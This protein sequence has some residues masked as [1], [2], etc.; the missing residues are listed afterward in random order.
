MLLALINGLVFGLLVALIASGLSLVFGVTRIINLAHGEFYMV[1][2][3]IT[4]YI[5]SITGSFLLSLIISPL[6]IAGLALIANYVLLKPLNYR[7]EPTIIATIGMLYVIQQ[8]ILF[9]F[10]PTSKAVSPPFNYSIELGL[11]SYPAYQVVV[12]I[13]ALLV[14]VM[15]WFIVYRT[16]V[17]YFMRASQQNQ[18]M[19]LVLGID[20]QRI[21]LYVLC[22]SGGLA[23]LAGSLVS[24]ITS[25]YYLM[26]LDILML[27]LIVT[28][29]GGLGSLE[30]T[31]IASIFITTLENIISN[32]YSPTEARIL[33][34]IIL[35]LVLIVRPL[36]LFRRG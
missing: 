13:I 21:Y 9:M 20:V 36:G 2:A 29:V 17:G 31:F 23:G 14:L 4:W 35:A 12:A 15:L 3:V 28:I 34:L 24:P 7:T 26:G 16:K 6:T 19:A 32:F 33:S 10:G 8:S 27:S 1:G 25:V 22:L 5:T 30:G 11:F 18:E